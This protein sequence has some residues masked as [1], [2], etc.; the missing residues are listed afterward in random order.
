MS[1][2]VISYCLIA[3]HNSKSAAVRWCCHRFAINPIPLEGT[4]SL[5]VVCGFITLS[6]CVWFFSSRFPSQ[7]GVWGAL[8]LCQHVDG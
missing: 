2:N 1:A 4:G 7:C 5:F 3:L 8:S 6:L